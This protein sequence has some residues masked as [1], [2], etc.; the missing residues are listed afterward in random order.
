MHTVSLLSI[1]FVFMMPL[2]TGCTTQPP[3]DPAYFEF[4]SGGAYH[5]EG[6]G[7]WQVRLE[8]TGSLAIAHNVQ[9]QVTTYGPFAL[10][11][12]EQDEI[13]Q[14]IRAANIDELDSSQRGGLPDEVQYTLTLGKRNTPTTIWINEARKHDKLMALVDGLA[15]LIEKYVGQKAV[16]K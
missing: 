10:T 15:V 11:E 9:G 13:W 2:V 6:F 8:E 16:L 5:I 12:Q 1:S 4:S 3:S 7:E 14:L